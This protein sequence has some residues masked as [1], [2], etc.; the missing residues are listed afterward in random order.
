MASTTVADLVTSVTDNCPIS[1]DN[2][3]LDASNFDCSQVGTV[4]VTATATDG[5]GNTATC[6][7]EITVT[8]A[9]APTAACQDLTVSLDAT[10]AASVTAAQINNGSDDNCPNFSLSLSGSSAIYSCSD[11]GMSY[12]LTLTVT[13]ES[14]NTATCDSEVSVVDDINPTITC[15]AD[16]AAN[17]DPGV[18]TA[19]VTYDVTGDDNCTYTITQGEGIAS[20]ADFPLGAT[21]NAYT[22]TD[23]SGNTA[24]CTFSVTISDAQAPNA[25][26][27]DVTVELDAS[28]M[29]TITAEDINNG[30]FDNCTD[31]VTLSIS[32][33]EFNCDDL[34]EDGNGQGVIFSGNTDHIGSIF[35]P[36]TADSPFTFEIW[37][38]SI[39][40]V[41]GERALYRTGDFTGSPS[42]TMSVKNGT[43]ASVTIWEGSNLS[44]LEIP[45]AFVAGNWYHYAVTYDGTELKQFINANPISQTTPGFAYFNY[46]CGKYWYWCIRF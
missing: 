10:G 30:S 11:V 14:N 12:T 1:L 38:K 2:V 27:Q 16:I 23:A 24:T 29:A 37:F 19:A 3:A 45:N 46:Y 41:S 35:A 18:C 22:I 31:P 8:D 42:F 43:D 15:P 13:D 25:I 33:T 7:S 26:C 20:G 9:M 6:T 28:G 5:G 17:T 21:D 34:T 40:D 4:T 36:T 32:Q 39:G 44:T